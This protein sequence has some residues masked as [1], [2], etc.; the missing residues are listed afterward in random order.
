MIRLR[1]DALILMVTEMLAGA[2]SV[3]RLENALSRSECEVSLLSAGGKPV[4][5]RHIYKK[6]DGLKD[7][8]AIVKIMAAAQKLFGD[9]P[10]VL[11]D[12]LI[13]WLERY[14]TGGAAPVAERR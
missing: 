3:T 14:E 6:S 8:Q 5:F 2:P 4:P 9:I 1:N 12:G 7:R 11:S 13:G 10:S